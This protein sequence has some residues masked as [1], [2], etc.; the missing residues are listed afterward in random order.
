LQLESRCEQE[1]TSLARKR[2]DGRNKAGTGRVEL[3]VL[4]VTSYSEAL[5]RFFANR[6]HLSLPLL[7]VAFAFFSHLLVTLEG[8]L[9]VALVVLRLLW[10]ICGT[11]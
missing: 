8:V 1:G 2:G 4:V 6:N 9:L 5:A 11:S 3:L 7:H 10:P